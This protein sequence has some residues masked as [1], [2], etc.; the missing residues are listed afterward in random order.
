MAPGV[1]RAG[2]RVR[3]AAP[4]V[5]AGSLV[6]ALCLGLV[7]ERSARSDVGPAAAA[8]P[9]EAAASAVVPAPIP[10]EAGRVDERAVLDRVAAAAADADGTIS[11]VVLDALGSRLLAGP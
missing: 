8:A 11:V 7:D 4:V 1:R 6:G 10:T 9:A 5:L 3:R 2:R